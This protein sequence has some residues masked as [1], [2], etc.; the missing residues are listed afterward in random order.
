MIHV[1]PF[2]V[3]CEFGNGTIAVGGDLCA[4]PDEPDNVCG[5]LHLVDCP[6]HEIGESVTALEDRPETLEEKLH[7][8]VVFVFSDTRSVDVI[9]KHL[10]LIKEEMIRG[11]EHLAELKAKE[12]EED[13]G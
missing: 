13:V 5:L 8:K 7:S 4:Y 9:V 10:T 2:G 1:R 6:A 3:T 12:Q 11:N